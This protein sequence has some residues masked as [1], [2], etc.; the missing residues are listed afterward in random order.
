MIETMKI[1][2]AEVAITRHCGHPWHGKG[3]WDLMEIQGKT[4]ASVNLAIQS[5]KVKFWQVRFG[6]IQVLH[7]R[8]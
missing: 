1:G 6:L 2:E 3:N 7:N 4:E 8:I 5:A